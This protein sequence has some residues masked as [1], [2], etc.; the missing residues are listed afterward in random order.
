[1]NAPAGASGPWLLG[2]FDA[3]RD[4]HAEV[5]HA[6]QDVAPD[7]RLNPLIGQSPSAKAPPDGGLVSV[8]CRFDGTDEALSR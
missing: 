4:R 7:H 1:M 8:H 5:G 2:L 6:I 3:I